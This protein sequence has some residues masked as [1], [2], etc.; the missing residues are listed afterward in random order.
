MHL[1]YPEEEHT[2]ANNPRRQC[3]RIIQN[4][5]PDFVVQMTAVV[6]CLNVTTRFIRVGMKGIEVRADALNWSEV[7][8]DC[9]CMYGV[10]LTVKLGDVSARG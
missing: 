2:N 1:I 10:T 4:T 9:Q 6:V 5:L 8:F 3:R 7:L